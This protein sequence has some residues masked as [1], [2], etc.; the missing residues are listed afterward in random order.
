ML[1]NEFPLMS[2]SVWNIGNNWVITK[3]AESRCVYG[4]YFEI[5][6]NNIPE[7]NWAFQRTYICPLMALEEIRW[8]KQRC[9]IKKQ[10]YTT[11][12][13]V[14]SETSL[15]LKG[16]SLWSGCVTHTHTK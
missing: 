14:S 9:A 7:N 15:V 10:M 1:R 5:G 13:C 11:D 2:F 3:L 16:T 4:Q 6:K 12:H 8:F